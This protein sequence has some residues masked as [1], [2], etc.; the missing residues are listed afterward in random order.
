M[1]NGKHG[2][3]N[4]GPS[5]TQ[6][7]FADE[8]DVNR[9]V[10]RFAETGIVQRTQKGPPAYGDATEASYHEAMCHVAIINSQFDALPSGVRAHFAN[11]PGK[12]VAAF[13]DTE[14]RAELQGLGLI[15]PDPITPESVYE[16]SEPSPASQEPSEAPIDPAQNSNEAAN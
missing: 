12:Y 5:M 10:K 11:D 2:T 14:R 9:I 7:H 1:A 8:C 16:D 6:I 4:F 15:E 3:G 13:E